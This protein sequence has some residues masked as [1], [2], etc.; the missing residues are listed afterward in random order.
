ML[1]TA[2]TERVSVFYLLLDNGRDLSTDVITRCLG[3]SKPTAGRA[4]AELKVIGLVEEYEYKEQSD[5][6]FTK[7]IRLRDDFAWFLS[8][9]FKKLRE[10]FEPI[11]YKKVNKEKIP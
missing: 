5:T 1:S 8:I 7:H 11:S 9:D 3:V 6:Q 4:M 2:Q 10:G